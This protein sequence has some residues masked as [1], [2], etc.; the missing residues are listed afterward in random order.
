[1]PRCITAEAEVAVLQMQPEDQVVKAAV[2]MVGLIPQPRLAMPEMQTPVAVVVARVVDQHQQLAL[3]DRELW[4]SDSKGKTLEALFRSSMRLQLSPSPTDLQALI[5]LWLP[6][7]AVAE[8]A[9]MVA[10]LAAQELAAFELE[11]D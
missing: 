9:A 5:M 3:V 11:P 1:M 4:L 8:V 7:A 6:A 10:V 2:E